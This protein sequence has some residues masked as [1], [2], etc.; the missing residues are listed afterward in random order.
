MMDA[1]LRVVEG[2][3]G[4]WFYHLRRAHAEVSLCG[5]KVMMTGIPVSAWGTKT[6]LRERWCE[7][8]AEA[9]ALARAPEGDRGG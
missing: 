3:A 4:T 9:A 6:H 5:A 1:D 7:T 8:C 2:I